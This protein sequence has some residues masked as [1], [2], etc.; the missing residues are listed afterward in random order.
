MVKL[1]KVL[2][3]ENLALVSVQH[4]VSEICFSI[5]KTI[6]P[7]NFEN[8]FASS[9]E[10]Q[11]SV[12]KFVRV[13]KKHLWSFVPWYLYKEVFEH[14]LEGVIVA[15]EIMKAKWRLDTKMPE[16]TLQ[17]WAMLKVAEV[18]YLKELKSLDVEKMPK[19]V[20]SSLMRNLKMFE[21]LKSLEFGSSTGDMTIHIQKGASMYQTICEG[22]GNMNHLVKFSLKYNCT[23]EFLVALLNAKNTLKH[24]DVEH[25]VLIK[26]VCIPN[27]SKFQNL[28]ELG[29]AK[30]R[31][32]AEGQATLIM[33]LK[34]LTNLPRGDFLCEALD[35]VAWEEMYE[36]KPY[37]ILKLQ[38]F[39]ASE[40][41]FFHTTDQMK[42]VSEMCPDIEE[43]LFMYQDS[44]TCKLDVLSEFK[45]LQ[46]IELWGGDFYI[47]HFISMLESIGP[48]LTMLDLHHVDNIDFRAISL[49]SFNC[50]NLK[51]L[52]F[53]G[54]G[55]VENTNNNVDDLEEELFVQQQRRKEHEIKTYLVPFYNLEE[56]SIS[57]HCP[58]TLVVKIL[59]LCLNVKKI[60]L[61]MHCQ[62]TDQCFDQVLMENKFQY[63]EQL[64]IRK[65]DLLT[66][67]TVSNLLLYCDNITS[68][69]DIEGWSR[70]NRGDLEELK[71]HM[72]D[73]NIDIMM[74]ERR[75][76]KRD[77]SLY[78]ICQSALKEMYPARVP[79]NDNY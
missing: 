44:Y 4:L 75:E 73:T 15:V 76:D 40:V 63:L 47:D 77:V 16:F 79:N 66:L 58:E 38:N 3:L 18:L 2:K 48:G 39:W 70:V 23:D 74:D 61:G 36:H 78:Q 57:N 64:E 14:V 71:D 9:E 59:S 62:A 11:I 6:S 67:K 21:G 42:L 7:T 1:S 28:E 33:T 72:R 17:I 56:I 20:R 29:I 25:S 22:I 35:W 45:K 50:Q 46:K 53:G 65:T 30:T 12:E 49:V 60:I 19:L 27:M 43:M 54:C 68:I 31:L 13:L 69:L 34:N 37:P 52:R 8:V 32:T 51:Y 5:A 24:L 55:L 41:Y 10:K 26:D